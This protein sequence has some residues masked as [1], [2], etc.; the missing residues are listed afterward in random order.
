MQAHN[1]PRFD[2]VRQKTGV[3]INAVTKKEKSAP[4][5]ASA[6]EISGAEISAAKNQDP[7]PGNG[8][9]QRPDGKEEEQ[10]S[11]RGHDEEKSPRIHSA[12]RIV[13]DIGNHPTRDRIPR[14][15]SHRSIDN[16]VQSMAPDPIIAEAG[17][18]HADSIDQS[19]IRKPVAQSAVRKPQKKTLVSG[20]CMPHS[21]AEEALSTLRQEGVIHIGVVL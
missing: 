17:V 20:Y 10:S 14:K 12:S 21:V 19:G 3:A 7:G 9:D 11:G 4:V 15:I 2:R 8:Q 6:P 13:Q 18:D 16:V 1:Y 5:I